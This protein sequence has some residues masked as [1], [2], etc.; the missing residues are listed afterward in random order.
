MYRKISCQFHG[1]NCVSIIQGAPALQTVEIVP[2]TTDDNYSP[3]PISRIP[4]RITEMSEKRRGI[5]PAI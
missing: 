4:G 2:M 3:D 5:R 1:R